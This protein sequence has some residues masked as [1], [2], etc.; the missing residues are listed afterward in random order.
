[1]KRTTN[2]SSSVRR[3]LIS[4]LNCCCCD[5][6]CLATDLT[7]FRDAIACNESGHYLAFFFNNCRTCTVKMC[8]QW[9]RRHML[10]LTLKF[11][12]SISGNKRDRIETKTV[13]KMVSIRSRGG[14]PY[15]R[16]VW[17]RIF[18]NICNTNS[19]AQTFE[20]CAAP[21]SISS[22]LLPSRSFLSFL[23]VPLYP[24]FPRPRPKG[25]GS[26]YRFPQRVRA[27]ARLPNDIWCILGVLPV[28]AVLV[29]STK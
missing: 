24:A 23:S 26:V 15:C 4:A 6:R 3:S 5:S 22:L 25:L 27:A 19:Q 9:T 16:E 2:L 8:L 21:F 10:L 7:R 13:C 14:H 11:A 28:R 29:Q 20:N 1:M 17:P 12:L 18:F